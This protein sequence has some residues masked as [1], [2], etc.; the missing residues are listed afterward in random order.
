MVANKKPTRNVARKSNSSAEEAPVTLMEN[1][2]TNGKGD[3]RAERTAR[4]SFSTTPEI[5]DKLTD[6][7]YERRMPRSQLIEEAIVSYLKL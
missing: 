5:L 7:A 6:E 4:T 3:S 1:Q 2:D